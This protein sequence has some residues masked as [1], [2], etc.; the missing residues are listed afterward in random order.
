MS[1]EDRDTGRFIR[2]LLVFR[3]I[4]RGALNKAIANAFI[5]YNCRFVGCRAIGTST[6]MADA[7]SV[8]AREGRNDCVFSISYVVGAADCVKAG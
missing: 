5:D 2:R 1:F 7:K 3:P 6:S 8:E 4:S